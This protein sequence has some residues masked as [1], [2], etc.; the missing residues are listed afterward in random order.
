[1]KVYELRDVSDSDMYF[2]KGYYSTAEEAIEK[3]NKTR[4]DIAEVIDDCVIGAIYEHEIG[5]WESDVLIYKKEWVKDWE[6][7]EWI[8]KLLYPEPE[9]ET[10]DVEG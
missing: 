3:L 10:T 9:Q 4:E 2:S 6:K 8:G 7:D 5:K 1:M